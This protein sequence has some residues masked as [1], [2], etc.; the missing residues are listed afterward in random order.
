M[1]GEGR[2]YFSPG[3]SSALCEGCPWAIKMFWVTEPETRDRH[4]RPPA[5]VYVFL[6]F[7]RINVFKILPWNTVRSKLY[8]S[9]YVGEVKVGVVLTLREPE[10]FFNSPWFQDRS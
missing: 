6:R 8:V 4:I 9:V 1:R 5:S 2:S 10:G 7:L 3:S